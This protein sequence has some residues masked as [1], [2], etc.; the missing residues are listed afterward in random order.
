MLNKIIFAFLIVALHLT[1]DSSAQFSS[2]TN[3][4]LYD[5]SS[6]LRSTSVAVEI[7]QDLSSGEEGM[8]IQL[9]CISPSTSPLSIQQ[10]L[11]EISPSHDNTLLGKVDIWS[12]TDP[13]EVIKTNITIISDLPTPGT[14]PAGWVLVI[15]LA[16][17]DNDIITSVE[18][19][20]TQSSNNPSILGTGMIDLTQ[21]QITSGGQISSA[22][23]A[24]I[25]GYT[26]NIVGPDSNAK[27][28]FISGSGTIAYSTENQLE[29]DNNVPP[30][31]V[32]QNAG[33]NPVSSETSN[34][35][36]GGSIAQESDSTIY[37][38]TFMVPT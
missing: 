7:D 2:D 36:Y 29:T 11:F 21:Q 6:N 13:D 1:V 9:N 38:Q 25:Y 34:M 23:L 32:F 18:F 17:D 27:T 5:S 28:N 20:V 24:P 31:S 15:Q 8:S 26:L 16:N 19:A 33:L 14:I 10:F 37:T 22:N 3:L 30:G 35:E 12:G 4:W